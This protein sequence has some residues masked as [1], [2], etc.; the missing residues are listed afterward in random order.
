V[1]VALGFP[2]NVLFEISVV[3]P[4]PSLDAISAFKNEHEFILSPYQWFAL[5]GIRWDPGF[6]RWIVFVEEE[7]RL[8]EVRSWISKLSDDVRCKV[9]M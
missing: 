8:L 3:H 2:G 5:R 4:I 7:K 9:K 1:R 6:A